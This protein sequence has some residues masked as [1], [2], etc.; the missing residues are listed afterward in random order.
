MP[1]LTWQSKVYFD[2]TQRDL[3]SQDEYFLVNFDAALTL[4]NGVELQYYIKNAFDEE[5]L[6]DAGNTGDAFGIPTFISGKPLQWG[7][8]VSKDF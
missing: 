6:I 7:V 8:R 2:N 1:N 4:E 3:I 5:Y